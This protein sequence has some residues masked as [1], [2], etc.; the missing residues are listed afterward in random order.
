MHTFRSGKYAGKTLAQVM[1]HD[2]PHLYRFASVAEAKGN[3][4]HLRGILNEFDLLRKKLQQARIYV[5]CCEEGCNRRAKRITLP[6]D[7]EGYYWTSA[8]FWCD[9]HEPWEKSGISGPLPIH[10]DVIRK[11]PRKYAQRSIFYKIRE[12]IGVKKRTTITREFARQFF[13]KLD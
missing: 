3:P 4:P 2:A 13:A 5:R 11:F 10:F 12:A 9:K 6:W 8:Y 7:K 1:L